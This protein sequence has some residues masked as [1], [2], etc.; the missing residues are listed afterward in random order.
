MEKE[1]VNEA[2]CDNCARVFAATAKRY[3]CTHC[4]KFYYICNSCVE[5]E[6]KCRHCGIPLKR[7]TE[8]RVGLAEKRKTLQRV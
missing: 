8:P 1:S 4:N 7:R 3:Y 6:P 5:A 2:T